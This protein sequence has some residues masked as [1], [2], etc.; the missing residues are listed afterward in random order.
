MPSRRRS[1]T[2]I[3]ST[4]HSPP[5]FSQGHTIPLSAP[6]FVSSLHASLE[7]G[8]N[9]LPHLFPLGNL[10]ASIVFTSTKCRVFSFSAM[11]SS[12][13]VFRTKLRSRM[14]KPCRR[15]YSAATFSPIA[16]T[17]FRVLEEMSTAFRNMAHLLTISWTS[18]KV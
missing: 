8:R 9:R 7:M 3:P 6:L 5:T 4:C 11:I 17:S 1:H 12:S 14:E 15:R 18:Q 13:P 10:S 2:S 16:P